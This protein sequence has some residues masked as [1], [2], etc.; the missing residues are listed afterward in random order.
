MRPLLS[1]VLLTAA[2]ALATAGS[3]AS[4]PTQVPGQLT[5]GVSLPSEGF[6]V[7]VVKGSEVVY[8]QGLE[9]DLA[10]AIGAK[11]G[12][13]QTMF[14]QSR[15]DRLYS[16][17]AKPWDVAVAEITITPE[18]R[19]T[20]AFSRPYME[21]DQGVLT[22][23]TLRRPPKTIAGLR[24]LKICALAKSTGA[25]VAR[26]VIAPTQPVLL[27]GNVPT[28]MLD[29]QTG[30]CQAVVYDAP[31]LGTLK[32]RA[33]LRYG[34]FAGVIETR[35]DYGIAMPRGSALL[36]PVNKAL[37]ALEAD[38]TIDRLERKWITVDLDALPVLK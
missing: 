3:A 25:V 22:A 10:R 1:L 21:V 20:S 13:P 19:R 23:Q 29:L 6:Q 14:V 5:V 7:G 34:P 27:V 2:L 9:I 33:P 36:D 4:P 16:A 38:G 12:L 31:A 15:F 28:L 24:G 37:A 32:S 8:A 26:D 18:R 35:E 30:R 11:L 17:G